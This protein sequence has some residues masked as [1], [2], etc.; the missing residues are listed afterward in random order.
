MK[1]VI[2]HG[3]LLV[4][5]LG[6]AY[7]SWTRDTTVKKTTGSVVLWNEKAADLTALVFETPERTV[8]LERKDGYF[9]GTDTK[10]TKKPK[11]KE[12]T[13][14]AGVPVADGGVPAAAKDAGPSPDAGPPEPPEME[15]V[16]VV[17]EFPV[18]EPM[19]EL[20]KGYSAMRALTNLGELSDEQKAEYKFEDTKTLSVVF[21]GKTHTFVVGDKVYMGKDRYMLDVESGVG[22]VIAGSLIDPLDT[23]ESALKP[24]QVIPTGDEVAAIEV[25]AGDKSKTVARI[26]AED[27]AGKSVKTWGDAA[28]K[29]ADQTTANFLTK[30]ETALKPSKFDAK[31]DVATLTKLVTV[32]YRDARG[33]ALG[34]LTL[35]K[36]DNPLPSS[37]GKPP[38][39]GPDYWIVTSKTRVPALVA[40]TS[41]DQVEQQIAGVFQ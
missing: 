30:I 14:D 34:E 22:Y 4:L 12:L 13:P 33:G 19:D 7:Q 18:G 40:K 3:V 10:V 1:G 32:A 29:K 23:G 41:G 36:Q 31:L 8:K 2:A 27:D 21:A 16:T 38:A 26:T 11:K 39:Q 20:I 5:M 6:F 15:D 24:K 35:Y 17:R 37:E 25:T 28:T 9:W